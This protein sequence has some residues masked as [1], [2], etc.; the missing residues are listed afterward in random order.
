MFHIISYYH[1]VPIKMSKTKQLT[2]LKCQQRC[3]AI[4]AL[5]PCW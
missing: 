3:G 2:K 5:I 4:G 1:Y